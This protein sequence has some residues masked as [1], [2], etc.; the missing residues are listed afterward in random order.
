MIAGEEACHGPVEERFRFCIM[1]ATRLLSRLH[2]EEA[3]QGLGEATIVDYLRDRGARSWRAFGTTIDALRRTRWLIFALA[4]AVFGVETAVLS[5]ESAE[6]TY[7]EMSEADWAHTNYWLKSAECARQTGAWL[8]MCDDAGRLKPI[9]EEAIGDDPGHALLLALWSIVGDRAISLVDV[10]TLNIVL[11][12]LGFV[13][14]AAFLFALRAYPCALVFIYL[15][16]LVYLRWTGVSP[17]WG[18]LGVASM[19]SVL[20][21]AILARERGYLSPRKGL[22]FIALGFAGLVVASLVRE[23]IALMALA[24]TLAVIALAAWGGGRGR[25]GRMGMLALAL[26]VVAVHWTP[27]ALYS[28]RDALFAV[29]PGQLVQRHGFSDIL[30]MGL[31]SVPNAFGIAYDDYLALAH[32]QQVDPDVVHCSPDFFRIMWTLYLDKIVSHPQEVMRIYL[33]KAGLILTDPILEPGLPLGALLAIGAVMLLAGRRYG[34]WRR[35]GFPQG[36]LVLCGTLVFMALFVAQAVLASPDR[37]YAM[38]VGAAILTLAGMMVGVLLRSGG[39]MVSRLMTGWQDGGQGPGGS[40]P[41]A[42]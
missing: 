20:P 17:H 11:N 23:V 26:A 41:D 36:E 35:L 3:G 32:A 42:P 5:F 21:M 15:G 1:N 38:P 40:A 8:V 2:A 9:S 30:Y 29:E 34:L 25:A 16:P 12:G 6:Q 18:L 14:L 4:I 31:G 7:G 28:L 19:A 37:G 39:V 27:Y 13:L 10:A 22:L 33:E 24:A